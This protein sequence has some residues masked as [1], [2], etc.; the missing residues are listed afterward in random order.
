M[1]S[2][3][4]THAARS[5]PGPRS[6]PLLGGMLQLRPD[7]LTRIAALRRTYGGFVDLGA[8]GARRVFLVT[9]PAA[10][11]HVLVENHRNYKKGLASQRLRP[12]LGDGSLLLE[13]DVWRR[14]RRL[15]Q[16]AF[17]KQKV[18]AVMSSFV[19]AA[20]AMV[21]RWMRRT[22]S[23]E[24][25]DARDEALQLTME[26]TLRNM[27]GA[28]PAELR[29]LVDAW[30]DI[31]EELTRNRM[32]VLPLPSL[33]RRHV[34]RD[35]MK[36]VR[37]VL[38]EQI[39]KKRRHGGDDLLSMLLTA[40][41]EETGGSKLSEAELRDEV[42]TIF[43]GGYE[44]SSN[45]LAFAL[46]LLA[47]HQDTAATHRNQIDAV[48]GTRAP[49]STDLKELPYNRAVLEETLRLFPPSWMVTREA[50]RDDRVSNY[51]VRAGDQLLISAYGVH[52]A[53]DLWDAP[54]AFRPERFLA[55]GDRSRCTF[56]PFG[57]GPR[58]CL[59]EQY[60]MTELQVVL[61]RVVQRVSLTL[62]ENCRI[63]ARAHVGLRPAEPLR[64]IAQPRTAKP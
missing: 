58:V 39:R 36:V 41:D 15:V 50:V 24:V 1:H 60:A 44:T 10:V 26:L 55:A 64:I 46:A 9:D 28:E 19:T 7:P 11:R 6:L 22:R 59:G 54:D 62:A 63:A 2:D 61:A 56:F 29:P 25:I 17:H 13:G 20:D 12:V 32:R 16:P 43:V 42:M 52:R 30:Q 8:L 33:R 48:L 35:A 34:V 5:A 38:D 51:V 40:R 23:G 18:A 14:R 45:A 4:V 3:R 21:D 47:K 31:Y 49:D 53:E 27:F 57:A 37:G